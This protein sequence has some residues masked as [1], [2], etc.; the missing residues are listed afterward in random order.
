MLNTF[1]RFVVASVIMMGCL[2]VVSSKVQAAPLVNPQPIQ[3]PC[4]RSLKDVKK[5]IWLALIGRTWNPLDKGPGAIEA[6]VIVRGKHTLVVD[7]KYDTKSVMIRYKD[8]DNLNYHVSKDGEATIH[9][10]AN[11]WM[12]NIANDTR[13]QLAIACSFKG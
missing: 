5:A 13:N 4:E 2:L 1:N 9:R 10:N 12:E 11:S 6:K 7:I 3:V 8:S